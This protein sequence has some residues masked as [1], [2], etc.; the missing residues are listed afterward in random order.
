M[1]ATT[2]LTALGAATL[3][4]LSVTTAPA[5][6]SSHDVIRAD[7]V[8]SQVTFPPINGLVPG[9]APWVLDRG[10]VRVR[11]DGRMD[12]RLEGLQIPRPDGTEDNPLTS[13]TAVVYCAGTAVADSGP[14]PLSVPGGDARFRVTGLDLPDTCASPSVLISPTAAV[15][16]A[17]IAFTPA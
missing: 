5:H 9:S 16:R 1:H 14:Q 3:L 6:A 10:E 4:S 12:V 15:G 8:P 2:R 13:I 17:Y 11:D 7:L